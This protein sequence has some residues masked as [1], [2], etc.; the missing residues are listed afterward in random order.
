MIMMMIRKVEFFFL[1]LLV[2]YCA[3]FS[4]LTT[5]RTSTSLCSS[6]FLGPV[7]ESVEQSLQETFSPTYLQVINESHGQLEDESHFKVVIVS[8]AFQG[9]RLV[10]RHRLVNASLMKEEGKL[11][12][13]ALTITAKT[14]EEWD[15]DD[16][17]AKSPACMGNH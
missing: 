16:S 1:L 6:S 13:H 8:D 12:F 15:S 9:K 3:S 14:T 10:Q 17:V 4:P 2:G 11:P 5:T 7:Q